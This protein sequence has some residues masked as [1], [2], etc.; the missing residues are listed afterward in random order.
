MLDHQTSLVD[1]QANFMKRSG[2]L[3]CQ[4]VECVQCMESDTVCT[5]YGGKFVADS[6]RGSSLL[7]NSMSEYPGFFFTICM[8]IHC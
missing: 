2:N 5:V 4:C 6:A 8:G 7:L 1:D 3:L